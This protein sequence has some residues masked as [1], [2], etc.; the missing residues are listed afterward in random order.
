MI[1]K[2][3]LL[4]GIELGLTFHVK[5]QEL[6]LHEILLVAGGRRPAARWLKEA[7]E[8]RDIFCADKGA[9]Y[10]F[11]EGLLPDVL[12]GDKDSAPYGLYE[13]LAALGTEVNT[14]PRAKH[15]TDLQLL[16]D[17]L[18]TCVLVASGIWGGRYDHLFSNVHSLL[19][20]K[21]KKGSQVLLA[22]ESELMLLLAGGESVSLKLLEKA[23]ALSLLPL[24]PCAL[25]D[26][27]GVRWPLAEAELKQSDPYA[28][29]NEILNGEEVSCKVYEGA[30]GLYL[31]WENK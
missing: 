21:M 8:T 9:A 6:P 31:K 25:V 14:Y 30:V 3:V 13:K 15:N 16:L 24:S 1:K 12:F 11:E 28:V 17:S 4:P 18:E 23:E 22:D 2:T 7:A 19:A 5:Q 20:Y 10:C 27:N 29:S 26:L